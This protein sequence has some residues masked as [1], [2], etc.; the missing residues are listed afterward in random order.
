MSLNKSRFT[1]NKVTFL[2]HD[3]RKNAP[4]TLKSSLS[5]DI[6]PPACKK[7]VKRLNGFFSYFMTFLTI[8][9]IFYNIGAIAWRISAGSYLFQ[10]HRDRGGGAEQASSAAL[11]AVFMGE[12]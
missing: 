4:D 6:K 10:V 8:F 11:G 5:K 9:I 3:S 12:R 7:D 2:G 1:Q